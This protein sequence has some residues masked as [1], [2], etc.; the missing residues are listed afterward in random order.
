MPYSYEPQYYEDLTEGERFESAGRT[1]TETDIGMHSALTGDWTE[2]HTN[3]EYAAGTRFGERIGHG[4]LTF[5]LAT[6]LF[7]RCG[8]MERTVVAFLGVD[9]LHFPRPVH[10]GDTVSAT[11][12]VT[13]RRESASRDGAGIVDFDTSVTND[14]DEPVLEMTMRFMFSKREA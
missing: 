1:V 2:V 13:G 11:F 12:E 14:D 7:A 3:A 8:V 4:P 6:G 5:S 10:I 9:D